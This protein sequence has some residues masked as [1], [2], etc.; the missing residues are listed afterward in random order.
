MRTALE[1]DLGRITEA[2]L[3]MVSQV[4]EM[5]S[6]TTEA[7]VEASLAKA[8]QVVRADAEVDRMELDIENEAL[9][10]IAKHQP[11]ATDL[12]F[13]TTILKAITDLERSG[14][15]AVH[16]AEDAA[17][18][19][20][21]PPLKRYVVLSEMGRRLEEMLDLLAKSIAENDEPAAKRARVLDDEVDGL[22]EQ[23]TRELLTYML[24]D[25]RTISKALTLI[26]VAR[27]YERLGDHLEN[28]AERLRFWQTGR[29]SKHLED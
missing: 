20:G 10:A 18:L 14:D 1:H 12:R 15:Y 2:A 26:R 6:A 25:P 9:S 13:I 8:Q 29:M 21:E 23:I 7:L 22:Y 11:V 16:I 17:I 5:V 3:R 19:A 4:R 24:E 28:V 27:S